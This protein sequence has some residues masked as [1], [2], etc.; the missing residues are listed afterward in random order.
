[1]LIVASLE[2]SENSNIYECFP[3]FSE[4]VSPWQAFYHGY[5]VTKLQYINTF[6]IHFLGKLR[7]ETELLF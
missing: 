7:G 5:K 3:L 4:E 6:S 2:G 1:M